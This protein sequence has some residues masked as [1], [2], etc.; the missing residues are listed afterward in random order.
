EKRTFWV[1][2]YGGNYTGLNIGGGRT[3]DVGEVQ[4]KFFGKTPMVFED[5]R[6]GHSDG[7]GDIPEGM[8]EAFWGKLNHAELPHGANRAIAVLE[9]R[10]GR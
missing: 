6:R 7:L 2:F 1:D 3:G 9:R 5:G 8:S 10:A 4:I